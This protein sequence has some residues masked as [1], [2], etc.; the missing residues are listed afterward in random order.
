VASRKG[1]SISARCWDLDEV[2]RRNAWILLTVPVNDLSV[3][4]AIDLLE[5]DGTYVLWQKIDRLDLGPYGDRAHSLLNERIAGV[6]KH[7]ALVFHRFLTGEPGQARVSLLINN[8]PIE[9]FDPF[10]AKNAAT[11]HL[12]EE[13]VSVGEEIVIIQPYVLPHHTKVSSE[14]YERLAGKE[15]YLRS[16]GFYVY[17]NRRLIR[18]G[19]WFHLGRQDELTKLARVRIDIPNTLDHF[20][21]I[22]VRKSRAVPPEAVRARM[23][24]VVEKIRESSRRPYTHRGTLIEKRLTT[25]VWQRRVFN[26]RISYEINPSHPL[27][28]EL[29]AD[30]DEATRVRFDSVLQMLGAAFPTPALFADYA[31]DPNLVD[32]GK[33]DRSLLVSLAKLLKLENPDLGPGELSQLMRGIEPFASVPDLLSSIASELE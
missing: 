29:R 7:L 28:E 12:P 24:Q 17:R 22:D 11:Q 33:P 8:E 5:G 16:Q 1:S 13:R 32:T 3:L 23:R 21:T 10:N 27:V 14:E 6:R 31:T 4:P 15:G 19:T 30:I 18:F 20:W 9:A 25:P 26:N 2:S